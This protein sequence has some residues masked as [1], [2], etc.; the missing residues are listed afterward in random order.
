MT[1]R[2]YWYWEDE[3]LKAEQADK[4]VLVDALYS[5]LLDRENGEYEL[6]SPVSVQKH[7]K[8]GSITIYKLF[9]YHSARHRKDKYVYMMYSN[10]SHS[11]Y[12]RVEPSGLRSLTVRQVMPSEI[13]ILVDHLVGEG[14]LDNSVKGRFTAINDY[15]A[16]RKDAEN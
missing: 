2:E 14:F 15:K 12:G 3:R 10:T 11:R 4:C 7:G 9:I 8:Y 1:E 16:R 5:S 6:L 13:G